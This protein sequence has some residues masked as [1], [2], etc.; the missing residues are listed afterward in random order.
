LP[1]ADVD[2]ARASG[3]RLR[4]R[5]ARGL[6]SEVLAGRAPGAP[7]ELAQGV[8]FALIAASSTVIDVSVFWLLTRRGHLG[9]RSHGMRLDG[10]YR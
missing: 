4:V 7:F 3:M 10:A 5:R 2:S 6:V 1:I 8:L 9:W